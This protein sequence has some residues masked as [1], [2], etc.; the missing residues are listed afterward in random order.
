M[1]TFSPSLKDTFRNRLREYLI[2]GAV[3]FNHQIAREILV[4]MDK[5]N[6]QVGK[7]SKLISKAVDAAVTTGGLLAGAGPAA[8]G[9]S[10]SLP[11]N[12]NKI[13]TLKLPHQG[14]ICWLRKEL[15]WPYGLGHLYIF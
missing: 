8:R 11:I 13:F 15:F 2:C 1:D 9:P 12:L 14:T 3:Q 5:D 4:S 7:S 10:M 6:A